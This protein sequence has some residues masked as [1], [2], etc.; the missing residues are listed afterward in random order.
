MDINSA[1]QKALRNT[2]IIRSRVRSLLSS[3]DTT[4]PYVLLS[5]SSI[6]VGDTVVR[7]G[8]VVVERPAIIVPPLTPQFE[9]FEFEKED[10]FNEDFLV[11]FLIVRGV[12]FPSFKYDNKTSSLDIYEGKLSDALKHYEDIL[13]RKEDVHTGLVVGPEDC[14]Q[15]S[16]LIFVCMQAARNAESDIRKLLEEYHRKNRLN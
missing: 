2:E 7:K 6:N 13:I 10:N 14:W 11:N 5:E 4:V 12:S 1:W 3:S 9:G 8:E 15:F 16:L